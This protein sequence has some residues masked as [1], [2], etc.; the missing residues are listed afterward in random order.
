MKSNIQENQKNNVNYSMQTLEISPD[1]MSP[2][3]NSEYEEDINKSSHDRLNYLKFGFLSN[4][5]KELGIKN[6]IN[7]F[8]GYDG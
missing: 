2:I 6:K 4:E 8:N 5:S 1:N 7:G 3:N